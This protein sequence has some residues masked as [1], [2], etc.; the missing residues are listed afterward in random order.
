[1]SCGNARGKSRP[2]PSIRNQ[3]ASNPLALFPDTH[4]LVSQSNRHRF[5]SWTQTIFQPHCLPRSHLPATRPSSTSVHPDAD[6]QIADPAR[7]TCT[8]SPD[9]LPDT[10]CP[11]AAAGTVLDVPDRLRN[12]P[13]HPRWLL[14]VHQ[15]K[16]FRPR[17]NK[18]SSFSLL[19]AATN[20][21]K[22][23]CRCP[24]ETTEPL[25]AASFPCSKNNKKATGVRSFRRN[26]LKSNRETEYLR[27]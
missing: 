24:F 22:S 5:L 7:A 10:S 2:R 21:T 25:S 8:S 20:Q 6:P 18:D 1:M 26:K 15:K 27:S 12:Y 9:G 13:L 4:R 11:R 14:A 16:V 23:T 3:T 19:S 17:E